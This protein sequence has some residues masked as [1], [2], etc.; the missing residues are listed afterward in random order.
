MRSL[1][2]WGCVCCVSLLVACPEPGGDVALKRPK[3]RAEGPV[4]ASVDGEPI[5][6]AEVE[7]LVHATKLTPHEALARLEEERLLVA[8]AAQRGYGQGQDRPRDLKQARVRALLSRVVEAGNAP[9]D[10]PSAAVVERFETVK[11]RQSRPEARAVTH[12]LFKLDP[13][14]SDEKAS[15]AAASFLRE[16]AT[17]ET[18]EAGLAFMQEVPAKGERGG[19][20]VVRESLSARKDGTLE[21]PFVDAVFELDEAALVPRVARTSYGYHVIW[22]TAIVPA[23]SLVLRDHE[24]RVRQQLSTEKREAALNSL[25]ET[26]KAKDPVQLDEG[27]V[28]KALADD[29]LLGAAP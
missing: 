5:T 8:Y 13:P 24:N 1:W 23:L 4:V 28:Q 19:V 15:A 14:S 17:K 12:V 2:R 6:L 29:R 21:A 11:T 18:S 3:K 22:V 7:E 25:I 16:V 27:V 20:P 9:E 26:L 10:M